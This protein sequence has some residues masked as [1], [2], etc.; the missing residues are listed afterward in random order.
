MSDKQDPEVYA[1]QRANETGRA[2]LVTMQGHAFLDAPENRDMAERLCG[3]IAGR[4][5]RERR[6]PPRG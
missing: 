4:F 1:Q 5:T 2:Y 3:G 6:H